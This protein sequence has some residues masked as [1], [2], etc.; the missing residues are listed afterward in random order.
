[1]TVK[2]AIAVT[3]VASM[4][5]FGLTG[6]AHADEVSVSL[7]GPGSTTNTSINETTN[8]T[9]N[10]NNNVAVTNVNTQ[11]ATS[12]SANV[13]GN[14]VGGS[15]TT[16]NASNNA[17][18]T[19]VVAINNPAPVF[20]GMGSAGTPGG[21]GVGGSSN[22]GGGGGSV[23]ASGSGGSSRIL[24]AGS[25][26]SGVGAA[27]TL[28]QTGPSDQIDVSALR[29]QTLSASAP[30]PSIVKK[31]NGFSTMLLVIAA[32]LSLLGAV[33]SAVFSIRQKRMV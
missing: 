27:M 4:L 10:T 15:A 14:T 8:V 6:L 25:G 33:G 19:T 18:T 21:T 23:G 7:T 31:T 24:G 17:T 16:G 26:G 20:P 2:R 9:S 1:M 28:P 22:V 11:I 29:S 5:S 13:S 32:A 30:A 3:S 12:G